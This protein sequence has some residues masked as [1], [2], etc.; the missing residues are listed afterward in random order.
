ML[1]PLIEKLQDVKWVIVPHE[2]NR[3]FSHFTDASLY[4]Q[5]KTDNRVLIVN[6]IGLL[7]SIYKYCDIAIVGGG[8]SKMGIHN[9]IEPAIF[10]LPVLFGPNDRSYPEAK[11]LLKEGQAFKFKN[12]KELKTLITKLLASEK[13]FKSEYIER[14][15]DVSKS[16]LKKLEAD[17]SF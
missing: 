17:F 7:S 6:K 13:A 16:I 5:E 11:A 9:I 12:E 3:D 1:L 10:G 15:K 2:I 14:N 4:D 8:F